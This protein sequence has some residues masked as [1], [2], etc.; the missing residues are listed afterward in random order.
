MWTCLQWTRL[1][2][3]L[4]CKAQLPPSTSRIKN[5]LAH[6]FFKSRWNVSSLSFI[7]HSPYLI[8]SSCRLLLLFLH[9]QN[10]WLLSKNERLAA[11]PPAPSSPPPTIPWWVL[12]LACGDK[13]GDLF[14]FS[15]MRCGD[16]FKS[17]AETPQ[18]A[19]GLHRLLDIWSSHTHL[20]PRWK[21]FPEGSQNQ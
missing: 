11:Q 6:L 7:A 21:L 5:V 3:V 20:I 15:I 17:Q 19:S 16:T 4:P 8:D 12:C 1:W 13:P 2:C 9:K 18:S 14:N 10:S